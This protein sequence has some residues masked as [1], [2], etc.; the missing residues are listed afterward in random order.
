MEGCIGRK[1]LRRWQRDWYFADGLRIAVALGTGVVIDR[2]TDRFYGINKPLNG[3]HATL[4][5][6]TDFQEIVAN[7]V[8]GLEN[9]DSRFPS[10]TA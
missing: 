3:D 9:F 1:F 2:V 10:G 4:I 7:V 5:S 6:K 8:D